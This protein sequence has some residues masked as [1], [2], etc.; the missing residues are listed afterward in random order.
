LFSNRSYIGFTC[1]HAKNMY[2]LWSHKNLFWTVPDHTSSSIDAEMHPPIW[3]QSYVLLWQAVLLN[4][5]HSFEEFPLPPTQSIFY[6]SWIFRR[7]HPLVDGHTNRP[8][9]LR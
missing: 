2:V 4:E 8:T 6:S 7:Y 3:L 1:I 9:H 5:F